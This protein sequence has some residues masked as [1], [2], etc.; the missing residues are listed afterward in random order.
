MGAGG[1]PVDES[2]PPTALVS[3]LLP[4]E[5]EKADIE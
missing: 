1:S 2:P 3:L 4:L 5:E